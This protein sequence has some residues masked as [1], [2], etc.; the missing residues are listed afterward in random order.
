M[1]RRPIEPPSPCPPHPCHGR[2]EGTPF[3]GGG[4]PPSTDPPVPFTSAMA[5]DGINFPCPLLYA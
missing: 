4:C 1:A 5:F 2:E 3:F